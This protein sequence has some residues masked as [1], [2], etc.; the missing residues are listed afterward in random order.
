MYCVQCAF[1]FIFRMSFS[2]FYE[3]SKI[4][5]DSH[6]TEEKNVITQLRLCPVV[7]YRPDWDNSH[8]FPHEWE[9]KEDLC[10]HFLSFSFITLNFGSDSCSALYTGT[11]I[12]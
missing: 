7:F 2:N 12:T 11:L 10:L 9:N 3:V 4:C 8:C 1:M 5:T 6:F